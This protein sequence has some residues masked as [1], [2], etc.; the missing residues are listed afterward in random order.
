MDLSLR[1]GHQQEQII[2]LSLGL[3]FVRETFICLK[4]VKKL[5]T[6]PEAKKSLLITSRLLFFRLSFL[7][8][9]LDW[10]AT[11]QSDRLLMNSL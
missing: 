6:E 11:E 2:Q 1:P 8:L 10:F 5:I 3:T 7:F 4:C 9:Y